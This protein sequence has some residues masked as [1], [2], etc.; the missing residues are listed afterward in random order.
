MIIKL[1]L[2][3]E[4]RLV[5]PV[6]YNYYIQSMIYNTLREVPEYSA[7]LHNTGYRTGDLKFRIFTFSG[8]S[9]HYEIADRKIT[10]DSTVNLEIRSASEEFIFILRSVLER[11]GYLILK[12]QGLRI[13]GISVSKRLIIPHRIEV[14]SVS[15]IVA[16]KSMNN[17]FTK[18]YSPSDNEFE[19][20]ICNNFKKKF[21]AFYGI[22][23]DDEISVMAKPNSI[24]HI[25]TKYH[26]T[27]IN[28]YHA[29]LV[30]GGNPQYL[31]FLYDAGLGAKN[32]QGFGM[33]E[34]ADK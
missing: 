1:K 16:S 6:N 18:Y 12:G 11:R 19:E 3:P 20:N 32:A 14:K 5:L 23:P 9:G 31:Q 2:M 27:I 33:F 21:N 17:G 30:L 25:I 15:P 22:T 29:N 10:F 8:L 4:N 28:A 24:R 13:C 7:F 26:D 34:I